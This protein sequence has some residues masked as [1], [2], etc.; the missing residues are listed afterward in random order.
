[1]GNIIW[2]A[3]NPQRIGNVAPGTVVLVR[4]RTE[5]ST[6]IL[7]PTPRGIVPHVQYKATIPPTGTGGS[8]Q[9]DP[10][11]GRIMDYNA[12]SMPTSTTDGDLADDTTYDIDLGKPFPCPWAGTLTL[13]GGATVLPVTQVPLIVTIVRST[14]SDRPLVDPTITFRGV[15]STSNIPV[16]RGAYAVTAGQL[17]RVD[18]T[19]W[20][21]PPYRLQL[22]AG[23]FPMQLGDLS[24]G[25]FN[26][27]PGET[28]NDLTFYVAIG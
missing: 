27:L 23:A 1:M 6:G 21:A 7:H 8:V 12:G 4:A 10:F 28:I 26:A 16:P 19:V 5:N 13:V 22:P 20:N 2:N 3:P 9:Y 18:F 15:T 24:M 17:A 14:P 11:N 25:I